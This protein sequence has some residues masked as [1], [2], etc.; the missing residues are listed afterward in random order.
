MRGKD[1][2]EAIQILLG[3]VGTHVCDSQHKSNDDQKWIEDN[4]SEAENFGP[5]RI[6]LG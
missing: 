5:R 2:L 6:R 3:I 1:E 4:E